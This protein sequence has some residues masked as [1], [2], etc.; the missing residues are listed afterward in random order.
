MFRLFEQLMQDLR[1]AF[2]SLL[3]TP[4][5]TVAVILTLALGIGANTAMFSLVNAYYLKSQPGITEPDRLVNVQGTQPKRVARQI[6]YLDYADL[7]ARNRVF[8]GLMAYNAT[9]V[10]MGRGSD[11]RRIQAALVSSNYFAVLGVRASLGRT[12]LPEEERPAGAHPVAVISHRLWQRAFQSDMGFAGKTV[13]LN[14]LSYTVVGVAAPGFRGHTP[15]QAF[16]IWLPLAMYREANPGILGSVDDRVFRWLT[17]VGRLAPGASITQAQAEMSILA[18]QLEQSGSG[19]GEGFGASLKPAQPSLVHDTDILIL[20]ASVAVLFLIVCANLSNLYLARADGRRKEIAT[21]LALGAPRRRVLQQLLVESVV[22]GVL[23]GAVAIPIAPPAANALITWSLAMAPE[24]PDP[25]DL[26]INS[27][28]LLFVIAISILSGIALGL[29]PALRVTR[30]DVGA[31]LRS[32][33]GG[34]TAGRSPVRSLLLVSQLSLSLIL[35]S[36]S[37]LLFKT[38]RNFQ[39]LV[40]VQRPEQVLLLSLQPSHQ[41]YTEARQREFFRRILDRVERLP[42]VQSASIARDMNLADSSFFSEQVT[43]E[44]VVQ[45]ERG[46]QTSV[47]YSVVAP[48]FFRTMGPALTQGRDFTDQDRE[49]N[50]PVVIVNETL[51]RRFWPDGNALGRVLWIAGENSG[52]EVIGLVKDRPAQDGPCPFLY[53]PLYQRDPWAGS[54]HV[55]QVRTPGSP[56]ALIPA[57]RREAAALDMNLPLFNPRSLDREIAGSRLFERLA[58]GIVGVSGLLALL[59]A[60]VGLYGVMR[61]W[62]SQRTHEIGV[63]VALGAHARNV[64]LLVVGRGMK[65]ALMGVVIGLA[66]SLA[67]NRVWTSF[68]YGVHPADPGVLGGA[69]LILTGTALAA[70]YLPARRATKIDPIESL[71]AE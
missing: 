49:G 35:L 15:E 20:I 43:A 9:V 16:D 66:S 47:A 26:G 25:V 10:D 13:V 61:Y 57:V 14:G 71:R 42:G 38:L 22:L 8:S 32:G 30:L 68:L 27:D 37:G 44:Q 31:G 19:N 33:V 17:V 40:S 11:T 70:S 21:R 36:G 6:T 29:G 12:F 2:R 56:W 69:A 63:R 34:R 64:L 7:R 55:L 46:S 50:P 23:G 45:K 3:R 54:I 28:L 52:R 62:V 24:F 51:A 60:S 41:Q 67:L 39:R 59:L 53:E 18:R 48:G 4:G 1:I 65:L 58:L 5:F